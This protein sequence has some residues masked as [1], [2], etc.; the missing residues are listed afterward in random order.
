MTK[1]YTRRKAG[2]V[3]NQCL[4]DALEVSLHYT[5][6][7]PAFQIAILLHH[8]RFTQKWIQISI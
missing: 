6:T 2:K 1:P 5:Y 8:K 7:E 4:L 3:E